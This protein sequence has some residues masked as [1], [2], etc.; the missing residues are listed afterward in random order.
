MTYR[1]LLEQ[2]RQSTDDQLDQNV[3]VCDT[4]A[5]KSDV[6]IVGANAPIADAD[7][8]PEQIYIFYD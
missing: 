1:E 5:N 7:Y 3:V 6:S 4:D 2:L 8:G